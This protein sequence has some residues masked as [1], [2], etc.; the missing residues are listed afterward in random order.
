MYSVE[1]LI[2]NEK[3][4]DLSLFIGEFSAI[5]VEKDLHC[6]KKIEND[7]FEKIKSKFTVDSLKDDPKVRSYRDFFWRWKIADPTRVRPASEALI[8]RILINN[9][10][11]KI[12]TFVNTYNLAS[13]I[14]GV[15]LGAYD[16]D[17]ILAPLY[18]RFAETDEPFLGIGSSKARNLSGK[19]LVLADRKGIISLYPHRDADRT[20]IS[21][22]TK[23]ALLVAFG[24]PGISQEELRFS[25]EKTAEILNQIDGG[26][27]E[28]LYS[29]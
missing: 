16:K 15:S 13:A 11:W 2:P 18:V 3:K 12:N 28:N 5:K 7:I 25:I 27:L 29:S 23:K 6:L 21:L 19:E 14:S 9:N 1:W 20:K 26:K 8:R 24:V 17:T 4:K 22:E 10:I